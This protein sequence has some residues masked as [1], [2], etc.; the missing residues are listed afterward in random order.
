[1]Q[2]NFLGTR[3]FRTESYDIKRFCTVFSN[4][5]L[6]LIL[7]KFSV[8]FKLGFDSE[9][10]EEIIYFTVRCWFFFFFVMVSSLTPLKMH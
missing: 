7:S 6:I 1:M 2:K 3:R 10:S 9:W 5:I 8:E 4:I